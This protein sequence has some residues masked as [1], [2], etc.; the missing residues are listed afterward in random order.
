MSNWLARNKIF[1]SWQ[2]K[3]ISLDSFVHPDY[4]DVKFSHK[5]LK[6]SFYFCLGLEVYEV[7]LDVVGYRLRR[8]LNS[9]HHRSNMTTVD[10]GTTGA[11]DAGQA[12]A[13]ARQKAVTA[14]FWAAHQLRIR[15]K[16]KSKTSVTKFRLV[17][18]HVKIISEIVKQV[19]YCNINTKMT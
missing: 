8:S 12:R 5:I 14:K 1:W 17:R 13:R 4:N 19:I 18:N 7:V 2:I 15:S 16:R 9:H 10:T 11:Y 3:I 6:L